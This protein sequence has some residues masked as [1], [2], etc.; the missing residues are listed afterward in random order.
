MSRPST[1][2]TNSIH[3]LIAQLIRACA[4]FSRLFKQKNPVQRLVLNGD[5]R[6]GPC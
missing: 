4:S 6:H 2:G 5:S 1:I 3:L